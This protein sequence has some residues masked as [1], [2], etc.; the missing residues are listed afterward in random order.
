[1]D[2]YGLMHALKGKMLDLSVSAC[3]IISDL[4]RNNFNQGLPIAEDGNSAKKDSAVLL[5]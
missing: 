4:L 1:M 2:F 5:Q 3:K